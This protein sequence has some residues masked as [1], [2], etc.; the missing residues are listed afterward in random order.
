VRRATDHQATQDAPP[1]GTDDV[2]WYRAICLASSKHYLPFPQKAAAVNI[3]AMCLA[4]RAVAIRYGFLN[5]NDVVAFGVQTGGN[6]AREYFDGRSPLRQPDPLCPECSCET[7]MRATLRTLQ[8]VYFR[9]EG[10]G[11]VSSLHKPPLG[12]FF[13]GSTPRVHRRTDAE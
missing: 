2:R 5:K 4:G 3:V 10:C 6:V 9:C 1:T 12:D 7:P 11:E 8:A 13:A